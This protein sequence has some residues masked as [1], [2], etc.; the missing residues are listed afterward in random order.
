MLGETKMAEFCMLC[1]EI[2]IPHV[3]VDIENHIKWLCIRRFAGLR[4]APN[5]CKTL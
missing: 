3:Q 2:A 4:K 5:L 1:I